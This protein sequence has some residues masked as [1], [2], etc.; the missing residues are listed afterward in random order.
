MIK[1]VRDNY[2]S[3]SSRIKLPS[4]SL[5]TSSSIFEQIQFCKNLKKDS[6]GADY[7][8]PKG[9]QKYSDKAFL[10]FFSC[11]KGDV[12]ECISGANFLAASIEWTDYAT[13]AWTLPALT[14][15]IFTLTNTAFCLTVHHYQ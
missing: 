9:N 3:F 14:Y 4:F 12:F 11:F 15:V 2:G 6:H 7:K 5:V 13:C 1:E 8:I 10:S